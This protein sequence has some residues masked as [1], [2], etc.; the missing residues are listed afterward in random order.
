MNTTGV[1]DLFEGVN[2][3]R[4]PEQVVAQIRKLI[5]RGLLKP[6]DMLPP[7][8]Q[9]SEKLGI[10]RGHVREGIKTL[11]LYGIVKSIQ[12][13]GTVVTDLGMQS[14]SS[15][16]GSLLNIT[17]D[18]VLALM[19]ARILIESHTAKLA[20]LNSTEDDRGKI[21]ATVEEMHHLD[22]DTARWLEVDLRLHIAIAEASHNPVL[23][24]L[25]KFM[26]PNLVKY[27]RKFLSSELHIAVELHQRIANLILT[28]KSVKAGK[29]MHEHLMESRRVFDRYFSQTT[30]G[31][32]HKRRGR[33][34]KGDV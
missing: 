20:A 26:T 16:L 18:D 32:G 19:D 23:S 12:G 10:S 28:G 31:N 21:L 8:R 30:P 3:T 24:E 7:E 11:E 15:M 6:G 14:M 33:R 4:P 25:V 13:K 5:S 34:P 27:Y 9:L 29:L 2:Y 1:L 17:V 22:G